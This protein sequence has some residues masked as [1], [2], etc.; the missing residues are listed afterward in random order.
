M[1]GLTALVRAQT[2]ALISGVV[3]DAK[4]PLAGAT[5]RIQATEQSTLSAKDGSFTL[6]NLTGTQPLTVTASAPGYYI[7]W[8]V[9]KPGEQA[10]HIELKPYYTSDN[11]TYDWFEQTFDH[12]TV[13]GSAAC[14]ECHTA[15]AEWQADAHSQSARNY[16][17][18]TLYSGTDVRGKQSPQTHLGS[19]GKY[20]PPDSTQPYYGPGFLLDNPGRAGSCATCH[21]PMA[22]KIPNNQNCGWSGCHLSSTLQ[23]AEF[24]PDI[25]P[26]PTNLKG[27]AAEGI[28][29]EF[30]HKIGAVTVND[31]GL[32]YDDSPGILSLRLF[33]PSAPGHDLIFG[34]LDD[35]ARSD[36]PEARDAYLPLQSESQ[37]C[38]GCH[39]GVM[40]G[41]VGNMQVTGGV[42]V[43]S[44]YAEWLA[45]PYSDPATGQTCQDCH[46][47]PV[48][49]DRFVF[50]EKG[51]VQRDPQQINNH[52]MLGKNDADFLAS[53]VTMTAT[54]QLRGGQVVVDV[55]LVN[56]NAGHAVPTDSVLHHLLL[57][58]TAKD[59]QGKPLALRSGATLPAWAG[60]YETQP[61]RAFAKII[62]D[63]N[64]GETPTAAFWREAAVVADT[65]LQPFAPAQSRY[66]FA[67]P[68]ATNAT[69][70]VKLIYRRAFQQLMEQKGWSDPDIMLHQTQLTVKK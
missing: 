63:K 42:L 43:Y 16:R 62:K 37:F 52:R 34:P 35:I 44:S 31:S 41:V 14:G 54:A 67:A 20:A 11:P 40:G 1:L 60:N 39:Y 70:Q 28:S 65:R 38:A 45:S 61:G 10:L 56:D 55:T 36:L 4:G 33:R 24:L 68:A 15:Y 2:P 51:G 32:P 23:R 57:V 27:D 13:T 53:A 19:D 48:A 25:M 50:A 3:I 30:C 12:G 7:G 58:V 22:A 8:Q 46:M 59:A 17:F 49:Y 29:C 69:V 5:V 6:S 26:S 66:T 21:T 47:P 18:L 64:S 9:A